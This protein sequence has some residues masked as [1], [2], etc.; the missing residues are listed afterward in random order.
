[1]SDRAAFTLLIAT[2]VL[3]I[4]FAAIWPQGYGA[5]SPWPFGHVPVQQTPAMRAAM[6][7][8]ALAAQKHGEKARAAEAAAQVG[9]GLGP[10]AA[11]LRPTQ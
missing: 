9:G 5:R 4:G 8:E 2:A 6:A 3:M 1:M 11:G 10:S 7:Q